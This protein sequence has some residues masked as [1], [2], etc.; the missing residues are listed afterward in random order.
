MLVRRVLY[1][2]ALCLIPAGSLA[3]T[4]DLDR[5]AVDPLAGTSQCAVSIIDLNESI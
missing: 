2:F 5:R 3:Q 4:H 1:A